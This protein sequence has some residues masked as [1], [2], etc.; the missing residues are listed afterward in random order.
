MQVSCKFRRSRF[1]GSFFW[2]NEIV[3][4]G[5]GKLVSDLCGCSFKVWLSTT[6]LILFLTSPA[7]ALA[8]S[9][10]ISHA[11]ADNPGSAI[12][13]KSVLL[14]NTITVLFIHSPH[15]G[16]CRRLEPK[17]KKLAR[18]RTDLNI[19]DMTLDARFDQ[20]GIGW[21]SPAARQFNVHAI[22]E[23]LIFDEMGRLTRGENARARVDEWLVE[24]GIEKR[25][26]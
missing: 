17:I 9:G 21:G 19:V 7:G 8:S 22:P 24:S 20:G 13:L 4:V 26:K 18:A 15:C 6:L 5:E 11:N 14:P 1:P 23:F 12:D 10:R 3:I 16:P 25:R 2:E